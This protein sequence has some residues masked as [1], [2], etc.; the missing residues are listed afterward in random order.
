MTA[1]RP[2]ELLAR[3]EFNKVVF[4]AP[5]NPV[6]KVIGTRVSIIFCEP[7]SFQIYE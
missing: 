1:T 5:R 4:P 3:T 6:N 2:V 7:M